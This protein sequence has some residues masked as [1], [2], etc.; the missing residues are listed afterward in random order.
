[1]LHP[2]RQGAAGGGSVALPHGSSSFF[3]GRRE[4]LPP[5]PPTPPSADPPPFTAKHPAVYA[6]LLL[7]IFFD[8]VDQDGSTWPHISPN[9]GEPPNGPTWPAS[10]AHIPK[11]APRRAHIAP[12]WANNI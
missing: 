9:R 8:L 7:S 11:M 6:V 12:R 3:L 5:L 2:R 10:W 4:G 1:V